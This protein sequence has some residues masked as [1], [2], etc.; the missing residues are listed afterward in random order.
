MKR[1]ELILAAFAPAEGALHSP[2]Q[3]QKLLFLIDRQIPQFVG[4]PHFKFEPYHYGPFDKT[5]YDD[6]R[7]M[8]S[9]GL[10]EMVHEET[11]RSCRLTVPGQKEGDRL[12]SS[13]PTEGSGFIKKVSSFVRQVSFAE[14]IAAIYKAYP[15]MKQNSVFQE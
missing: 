5:I 10:L 7:E 3:T 9:A 1:R 6:L 14:L 4:G 12:L 13:I 8:E 11:W 15:E 2:A